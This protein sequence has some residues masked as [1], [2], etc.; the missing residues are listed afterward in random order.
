MNNIPGFSLKMAFVSV[1]K[2]LSRVKSKLAFNMTKRQLICFGI[3]AVLGIPAYIFTRKTI[4]NTGA[5]LLM[6]GIMLPLFFLAMYEKDGQPAEKVI[7]NYIRTKIYW[8]GIRPYKTENFYAILEKEGKN[9]ATQNKT[10]AKTPV[11][12]R[13]SGK[14]KPRGH[15]RNVSAKK[16][17]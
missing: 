3:A 7:R 8:P 12:K 11:G 2:D 5:A 15:E 9:G 10:A 4:G 14:G 16:R 13:P 6:M 1:P 17:K